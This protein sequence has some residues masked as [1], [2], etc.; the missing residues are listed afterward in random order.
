MKVVS[1]PRFPYPNFWSGYAWC[2]VDVYRV[3]SRVLVVLR[4]QNDH[5]GTSVKERTRGRQEP[6]LF[7]ERGGSYESQCAHGKHQGLGGATS[8]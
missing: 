1:C 2:D 4:D 5:K 7:F 8:R 6:P 3:D